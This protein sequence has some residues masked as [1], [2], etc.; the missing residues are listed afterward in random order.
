MPHMKACYRNYILP[1]ERHLCS[2]RGGKEVQPTA[3]HQT[4]TAMP[5]EEQASQPASGWEVGGTGKTQSYPMTRYLYPA[6]PKPAWA[7]FFFFFSSGGWP[8]RNTHICTWKL[9]VTSQWKNPC[10]KYCTFVSGAHNSSNEILKALFCCILSSLK[11]AFLHLSSTPSCPPNQF[12]PSSSLASSSFR[13]ID[14][15]I[16]RV[17]IFAHMVQLLL[18]IRSTCDMTPMSGT[19]VNEEQQHHRLIARGQDFM[20]SRSRINIIMVEYCI[21]SHD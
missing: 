14:R 6:P 21:N 16:R 2:S 12:V 20:G 1:S 7:H 17:L 19:G 3:I 9:Q 18:S 8:Y 13:V 11:W 15:G 4:T 5:P 10:G